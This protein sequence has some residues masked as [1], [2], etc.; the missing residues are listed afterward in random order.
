VR[1][2]PVHESEIPDLQEA[3]RSSSTRH[4]TPIVRI[5]GMLIG[6]G[7]PGE[8]TLAIQRAYHAWVEEHVEP[9]Y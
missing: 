4:V 8:I 7:Q 1:L 5:N 6:D 9:I 3:F 2:D